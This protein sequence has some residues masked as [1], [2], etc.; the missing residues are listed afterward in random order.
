MSSKFAHQGYF[1]V[2]K[3]ANNA[4]YFVVKI[5]SIIRNFIVTMNMHTECSIV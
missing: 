5:W 2:E 3:K 4:C 1:D